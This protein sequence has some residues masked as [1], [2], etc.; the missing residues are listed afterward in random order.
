MS[1]QEGE[2]MNKMRGFTLIELMIVVAI[3]AIIAAIAVPNMLRARIQTNEASAVQGLRSIVSAETTFHA[4]RERYSI[5]MTELTT[6]TPP[7]LNGDWTAAKN[8]YQFTMGGTTDNYNVNANPL[9]FG[10]QGT[11]GFFCDASG[12]IRSAIGPATLGSL[13]I[14]EF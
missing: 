14:G 3:I 8:G 13:P 5:V 1:G 7:F 10:V 9:V 2:P 4:Q 6:A 11:R 12:V